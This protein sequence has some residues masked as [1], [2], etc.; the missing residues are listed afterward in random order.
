MAEKTDPLAYRIEDKPEL[1]MPQE[2]K[3]YLEY[4]VSVAIQ[5]SGAEVPDRENYNENI[6]PTGQRQRV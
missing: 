4:T 2:Y 3:M 1:T 6:I 5:A